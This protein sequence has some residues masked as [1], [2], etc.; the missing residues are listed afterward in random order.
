M[1]ILLQAVLLKKC[2]LLLDS[3]TTFKIKTIKTI[4]DNLNKIEILHEKLEH[5]K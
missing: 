3:K 5:F 4:Y 2:K 1:S